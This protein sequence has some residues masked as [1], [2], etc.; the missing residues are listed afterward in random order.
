MAI[1][2]LSPEEVAR[3]WRQ[4]EPFI[5]RVLE[6]ARGELTLLDVKK[7]VLSSHTQVWVSEER[8]EITGVATT[9]LDHYPNKRV[10]VLLHASGSIEVKDE[11]LEKVEDWARFLRA[12]SVSIWGRKGWERVLAPH[13]YEYAYTVLEKPLWVEVAEAARR[14]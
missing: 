7:D 13:G 10:L 1:R 6:G 3:Y 12:D 11:L 5:L 9:H 4:L 14:E 2:M 8:G